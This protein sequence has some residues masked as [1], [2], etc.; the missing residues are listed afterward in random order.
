[1]HLQDSGAKG[2]ENKTEE[3]KPRDLPRTGSEDSRRRSSSRSP[4]GHLP[5]HR[6]RPFANK[7][8][9]IEKSV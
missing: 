7:V 9:F 5:R 8:I 6:P 3:Q 2:P 4:H 1:M